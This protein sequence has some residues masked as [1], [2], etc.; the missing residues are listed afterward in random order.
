MEEDLKKRLVNVEKSIKR[1]KPP[2]VQKPGFWQTLVGYRAAMR[3]PEFRYWVRCLFFAFLWIIPFGTMIGKAMVLFF[4]RCST[5]SFMFVGIVTGFGLLYVFSGS[6]FLS[7]VTIALLGATMPIIYAVTSLGGAAALA[8]G[9][10]YLACVLGLT[11]YFG[12][13]YAKRNPYSPHRQ[14]RSGAYGWFIAF[15]YIL[16]VLFGLGGFP[17]LADRVGD[18][19]ASVVTA[20][21]LGSF[22]VMI[23]FVYVRDRRTAK[24]LSAERKANGSDHH[25]FSQRRRL[26]EKTQHYIDRN[27]G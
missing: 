10:G 8:H 7:M 19:I 5:N 20:V 1:P 13:V 15:L 26:S 6:F 27:G 2:V 24:A 16:I 23:Y 17:Y 14:P 4:T 9:M 22:L 11:V 12:S 18:F 21:V 3:I 25:F